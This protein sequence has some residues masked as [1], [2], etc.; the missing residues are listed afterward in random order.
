MN[1]TDVNPRRMGNAIFSLV[2]ILVIGIFAWSALPGYLEFEGHDPDDAY[3]NLLVQGFQAGQLSV[4]REP[5]AGLARL[6]DPYDPHANAPYVWDR[7]HLSYEMSYYKGKLYLYYGVTPA[8]VLFWPYVTLTGHYLSHRNAC[9][10]FLT[11]GFVAAAVVIYGI[12]RRYFPE[13]GP[14]VAVSGVL[15]LGLAGGLLEILSSCDVYEVAISC[16]FAFTMIT[17]AGIWRGLN[18]SERTIKWLVLASLAYGLAIGARP[19]LL[20][21]AII[22]LIPFAAAWLREPGP[23]SWLRGCFLL[24]A[25]VAPLFLVGIDALQ[26]SALWQRI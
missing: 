10:I 8:V 11:A 23:V 17:L 16:G 5:A 4:K 2:C 19:S 13:T 1:G 21:G 7:G 26:L 24:G 3:Y 12:W 15:A 20:F 22:L 14:W 9:V 25:A 18:T 6:P